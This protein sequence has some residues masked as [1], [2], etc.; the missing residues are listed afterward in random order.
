MLV[1][2]TENHT[3]NRMPVFLTK[4]HNV[5]RILV[6]LTGSYHWSFVSSFQLTMRYKVTYYNYIT[7]RCLGFLQLMLR[8][9][10]MYNWSRYNLELELHLAALRRIHICTRT[11]TRHEGPSRKC[12][13]MPKSCLSSVRRTSEQASIPL[14]IHWLPEW[15]YVHISMIANVFFFEVPTPDGQRSPVLRTYAAKVNEGE[16][17]SPTRPHYAFCVRF[18][19]TYRCGCG[20]RFYSII[21]MAKISNFY[22]PWPK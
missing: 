18:A 12:E 11:R 14:V 9:Q 21:C 7:T 2:S 17:C 20:F 13:R 1:L 22:I 3:V 5:S 16:C 4:N 19:F 8:Y 6:F 15:V 10:N